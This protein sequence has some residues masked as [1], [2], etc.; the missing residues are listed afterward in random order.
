M[1][2]ITLK[3]TKIGSPYVIKAMN[4]AI[5][6]GKS[7]V[8]G[9]EVNGGFLNG[10]DF[11]ING[12]TLKALPTRDAF[13]PLLCALAEATARN[14]AVS[15]LF[16]ALPRI[17][18][19]AGLIDNFPPEAGKKI[20]KYYSLPEVTIILQAEFEGEVIKVSDIIDE[21]SKLDSTSAIYR[22]LLKI[23]IRLEHLFSQKLGFDNITAINYLDGVRITFANGDI[24]HMRPS[25]NA[26]QFRVYSSAGSPERAAEIIRLCMAEPDGIIRHMQ[27]HLAH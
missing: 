6:R 12:N 2:G 1:N 23:K 17:Y 14:I 8:V 16:A 9:W 3:Q 22:A 24:A 15:E 10:T 5:A 19:D 11:L 7:S 18:T 27:K 20:L 25:G 21:G 26:P 13:L 4:E